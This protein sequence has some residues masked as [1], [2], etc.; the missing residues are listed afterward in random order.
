MS[1]RILFDEAIKLVLVLNNEHH[2]EHGH[3]ILAGLAGSG[4][5]FLCYLS[6]VLS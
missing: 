6:S 1:D 5:K 2:V 4:K 3:T